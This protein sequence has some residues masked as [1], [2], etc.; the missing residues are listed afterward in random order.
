MT[1]SLRR[2]IHFN[3]QSQDRSSVWQLRPSSAPL[4]RD[5]LDQIAPKRKMLKRPNSANGFHS[6][7]GY[8]VLP[9]DLSKAKAVIFQPSSEKEGGISTA[10]F[11]EENVQIISRLEATFRPSLNSQTNIHEFSDIMST[12]EFTRAHW[13]E[14]LLI[15]S[16]D[17]LSESRNAVSYKCDSGNVP[18]IHLNISSNHNQMYEALEGV[19]QRIRRYTA[20]PQMIG[21][22]RQNNGS[23][24][25][26]ISSQSDLMQ[27][28]G[29]GVEPILQEVLSAAFTFFLG[30]RALVHSR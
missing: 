17:T 5:G 15:D 10:Q 19:E 25:R 27:S 18:G 26:K 13:L 11:D 24:N 22:A 14:K 4:K 9:N 6:D 2:E 16:A 8:R 23:C 29:V 1:A 7:I 20:C 3:L 12:G 30:P 28:I 21:C